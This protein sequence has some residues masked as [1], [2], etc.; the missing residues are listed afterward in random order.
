MKSRHRPTPS[1]LPSLDAKIAEAKLK[2]PAGCA[3]RAAKQLLVEKANATSPVKE[4]VSPQ[5]LAALKIALNVFEDRLKNALDKD[6]A[7]DDVVLH[8]QRETDSI[9][10]ILGIAVAIPASDQSRHPAA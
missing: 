4:Q 5:A 2:D 1:T 6:V 8:A 9:R 7:L 10:Q 3:E